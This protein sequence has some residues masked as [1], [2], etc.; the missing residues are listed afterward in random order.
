MEMSISFGRSRVSGSTCQ[1]TSPPISRSKETWNRKP[2]TWNLI[3]MLVFVVSACDLAGPE[4]GAESE[5]VVESYQIAGQPLQAVYLSRSAP[6]EESYEFADVAVSGAEVRVERL[7]VEGEVAATYSYREQE[8]SAG[9]Y[10]PVGFAIVEPLATYRL[11]AEPPSAE[12]PVEAQT[13]VPDTFRVIAA[14]ADTV[15]YQGGEQLRVRVSRSE[16]PGRQEV[17]LFT[18]E[19]LQPRIAALTPFYADI[20]ESDDAEQVIEE[21]RE[22]SSPLLNAANY[23][24]EEDRSLT[25]RMPWLMFA[26]Y[27]PNR[28]TAQA[29]DD[30][31]YDFLRSQAVQQG[32]P[33]TLGPGEIP[34][35]LE[36][37]DGG[38]GI[39]GSY[40]RASLE[41]FL[42]N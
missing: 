37:V 20:T 7:D 6:I 28:L 17:Y 36:H 10:V 5:Y 42:A 32:G 33:T 2:V 13:V 30:N 27:G 1:S 29:V 26:F 18:N 38:T 34:S 25:M 40:A 41:V 4:A 23:G 22:N 9:I 35:I 11:V 12:E 39:F 8:E 3:W 15:A 16:Y 19:A 31:L 14:T 24:T 21:Y